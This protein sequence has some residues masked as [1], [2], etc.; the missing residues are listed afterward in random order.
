MLSH[1]ACRAKGSIAIIIINL[2]TYT[3][4]GYEAKEVHNDRFSYYLLEVTYTVTLV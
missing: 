4:K 2:D 3:A 1:Y